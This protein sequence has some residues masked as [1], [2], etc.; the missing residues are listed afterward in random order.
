MIVNDYS[1]GELVTVA[2][3]WRSAAAVSAGEN[4]LRAI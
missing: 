1:P 4:V 2:D 3:M